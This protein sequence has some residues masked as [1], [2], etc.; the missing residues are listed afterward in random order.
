MFCGLFDYIQA[1]LPEIETLADARHLARLIEG[2]LHNHARAEE[3]LFLQLHAPDATKRTHAR[4][5]HLEHHEIDA[6]IKLVAAAKDLAGAQTLLGSAMAASRKHFAH[7]ERVWFPLVEKRVE[8]ETLQR[9][10][11]VWLLRHHSPAHW[12]I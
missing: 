6:R 2:L 8:P 1:E 3:D 4:R 12:T 5:L 7:E 9:L 11:T 10:G